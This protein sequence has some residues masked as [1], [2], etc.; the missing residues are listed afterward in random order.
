M[1]NRLSWG[2]RVILLVALVSA[3]GFVATITT[4]SL[5]ASAAQKETAFAHA[6]ELA[7]SAGAK[8]AA[9]IQA[10]LYTVRAE[11][12]AIKGMKLHGGASRVAANTLL[13]GVIEGSPFLVGTA[14]CWEP[15]AFDGSDAAWAGKPAHDGTGRFIPYWYRAGSKIGVDPLVDYEKPGAGDWYLVPRSTRREALAEPYFYPI[16]GKQ[17]FMTTISVPIL[18]NGTFVGVT[19]GDMPITQFNEMAAKIKP[20]GT[21]YATVISNAGVLVAHPDAGRLNTDLGSDESAR[22]AKAAIQ[23]GRTLTYTGWDPHLKTEVFRVYVPLVI[24]ETGTPWA[25]AITVPLD[26]ILA[27]AH[28]TRN[29][30]I[31]LGILFILA[32]SGVLWWIVQRKVVD[33]LGGEP[34]Y[35]VAITRTIAGGDLTVAVERR[36]HDST[37]LLAS[38]NAMREQLQGI[39]RQ[40]CLGASQAASGSTELSATA[41]Q[42]A[43]TTRSLNENARHQKA[44]AEDMAA[45]MAQLSASITEVASHVHSVERRI[46]EVVK[47]TLRGEEAERAAQTAMEDIRDRT[48]HM[49]RAIQVIGEIAR[50]TN[51]LSLNAAIEAAKAGVHG[52]GFAVVAEEVRKLAERSS[53]S[54]KEIGQLI[55]QSNASV[56]QGTRAFRASGQALTDIAEEIRRIS[57]MVKEI[58]VAAGEQARTGDAVTHRVEE[59]TSGAA[60]LAHATHELTTVVEE[61]ARTASDLA[62]VAESLSE[63]SSRFRY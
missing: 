53:S 2:T 32:T 12:A 18:M 9:E 24:G 41:E 44:G 61:V 13:R 39:L 4:V 19:T 17:V 63:T 25:F 7:N 10:N 35:A 27:S 11:A 58:G 56:E 51:L 37:S 43:A 28:R 55:E 50:Q 34:D 5:R 14:T 40:V 52:K 36:P 42:M 8:I 54:S 21:G 48:E 38:M 20:Y 15:N 31:G 60:Q 16:D 3:I 46:E 57:G 6:E 49:V 62:T 47:L 59:G 33:P 26:S 45:S 30:A 29:I 22:K 23:G 1:F